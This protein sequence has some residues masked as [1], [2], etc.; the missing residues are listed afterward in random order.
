MVRAEGGELRVAQPPAA[1]G[2]AIE[3]VAR[4]GLGA[5]DG[6]DATLRRCEDRIIGAHAPVQVVVCCIVLC[7]ATRYVP[8]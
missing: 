2:A 6:F 1:V 4:G 5:L 7:G 3:R 8:R